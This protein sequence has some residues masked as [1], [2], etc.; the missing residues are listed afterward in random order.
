[1]TRSPTMNPGTP[2]ASKPINGFQYAFLV[3]DFL[4][5]PNRTETQGQQ[6]LLRYY[7]SRNKQ[8][9]CN[10]GMKRIEQDTGLCQQTITDYN[11][12]Y[13]NLG[14]LGWIRGCGTGGNEGGSGQSNL[15]QLNAQ[16]LQELSGKTIPA[17]TPVPVEAKV[18][19]TTPF[20]G[21]T[22]PVGVPKYQAQ[23]NQ[24][25]KNQANTNTN[26]S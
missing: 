20:G 17:T 23:K 5:R 13:K 22:T 3:R 2:S 12:Y 10:P 1:M 19:A 7:A 6:N 8:G 14:I 21:A 18:S 25:Q 26:L 16:K 9:Q 15:Y 11:N 4:G 24:A